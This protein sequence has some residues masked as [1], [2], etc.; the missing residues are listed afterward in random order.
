MSVK[1]KY[2]CITGVEK[3][4]YHVHVGLFPGGFVPVCTVCV[5]MYECPPVLLGQTSPKQ[6]N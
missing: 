6:V 1:V 4:Q 3:E 2:L 5:H